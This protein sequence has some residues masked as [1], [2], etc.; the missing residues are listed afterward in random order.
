M[1]GG[2]AKHLA[3]HSCHLLKVVRD[4]ITKTTII[5]TCECRMPPIKSKEIVN[6]IAV[7]PTI[8]HVLEWQFV[9]LLEVSS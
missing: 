3:S 7:R 9:K 6:K 4:R 5:R 1:A 2:Y 8:L